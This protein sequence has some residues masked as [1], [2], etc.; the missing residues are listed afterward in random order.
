MTKGKKEKMVNQTERVEKT[1]SLKKLIQL[2]LDATD[3][4]ALHL[5]YSVW[6]YV[7][8]LEFR[9]HLEKGHL[10]GS[11][12][13]A[14]NITC[15]AQEEVQGGYYDHTLVTLHPSVMCYRCY[16]A[17]CEDVIRHEIIHL[18]SNLRHD[19]NVTRGSTVMLCE[20]WRQKLITK[21]T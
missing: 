2:Y 7:Q 5:F 10:L 16:V 11:H 3:K 15:Y 19:V 4:L 1:G 12:D 13:F 14:Q 21:L 8:V 20:L 18:S 6:Q 9:Q 17:G